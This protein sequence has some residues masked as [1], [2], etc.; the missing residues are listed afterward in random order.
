M[1]NCCGR[2]G[3]LEMVDPG[4]FARVA[5]MKIDEILETG[6]TWW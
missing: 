6:Q 4:L 3:N 2:G 5:Q 1:A